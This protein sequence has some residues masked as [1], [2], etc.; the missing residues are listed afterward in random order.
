MEKF[1]FLI[2]R[3]KD[4]ASSLKAMPTIRDQ[5]D[6][7]VDGLSQ[8]SD[9]IVGT[10][11]DQIALDAKKFAERNPV[12]TIGL[13]TLIGLGAIGLITSKMSIPQ[14]KRHTRTQRPS[15]NGSKIGIGTRSRHNGQGQLHA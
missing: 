6:Y 9:Y 7:V 12:L 14:D 11:I 10:E 5:V 8:F 1:D 13:T 4:Y 3:T 2:E 15:K